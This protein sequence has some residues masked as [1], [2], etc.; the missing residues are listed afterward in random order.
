L[1]VELATEPAPRAD[2]GPLARRVS[3]PEHRVFP[4]CQAE[5]VS[6]IT[7]PFG[8]AAQSNLSSFA[9]CTKAALAVK[10]RTVPAYGLPLITARRFHLR[11]GFGGQGALLTASLDPPRSS[12]GNEIAIP[13]VSEPKGQTMI[14]KKTNQ[15]THRVY[16]VRK[17]GQDT[18]YW[19][20]IGAAWANKHGKGFSLKFN[21][22]LVGEADIVVREIQDA[23]SEG[24]TQR[25]SSPKLS[26]SHSSTTTAVRRPLREHQP[27]S[28]SSR[29]SSC[30]I[31]AE[32]AP[33]S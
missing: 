3:G 15:P 1:G 27:K 14:V 33:G 26:M 13:A 4:E 10:N 23:G 20:E 22:L 28:T 21:L 6:T 7:E 32:P 16:A 8:R 29:S 30:S 31:H 11:Q 19:A 24:G 9:V 18:S 2:L 17:T 12:N 5:G 25:S